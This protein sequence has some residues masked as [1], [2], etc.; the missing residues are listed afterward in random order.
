MQTEG[1]VKRLEQAIILGMDDGSVSAYNFA[2]NRP[3]C[4]FEGDGCFRDAGLR[5]AAVR[6]GVL[7][8]AGAY[9]NMFY[10]VDLAKRSVT[11]SARLVGSYPLAVEI[12]GAYG[13]VC[14]ADTDSLEKICLKT[15]KT[16]ISTVLPGYPSGFA[17]MRRR[18]YVCAQNTSLLYLLDRENLEIIGT[19]ELPLIPMGIAGDEK[20]RLVYVSGIPRDFGCEGCI[21]ALDDSLSLQ[22]C[23]Q[24]AEMPIAMSLWGDYLAVSCAAAGK[25]ALYRRGKLLPAGMIDVGGMT[26]QLCVSERKGTILV[27]DQM[28]GKISVLNAHSRKKLF[29]FRVSKEPSAILLY[30]QNPA[31]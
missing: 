9:N 30:P 24:T 3:E 21:C 18:C 22:A 31:L 26:D 2:R 14:C 15:G 23:T 10:A 17:M 19:Q 12:S 27:G 8:L 28:D 25:V 29:A 20:N 16:H 1:W 4:L 13:Y 11:L 6:R 5:A 7:Y